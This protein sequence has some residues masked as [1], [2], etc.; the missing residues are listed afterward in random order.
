MKRSATE[1]HTE[2]QIQKE[3]STSWFTPQ[4]ASLKPRASSLLWVTV[5]VQGHNTCAILHCF[6][7][8][9]SR[10]VCSH[11]ILGL[12]S[13]DSVQKIHLSPALL[14]SFSNT[15]IH[16]LKNINKNAFLR[17][18]EKDCSEKP[19]AQCAQS[20]SLPQQVSWLILSSNNKNIFQSLGG[21]HSRHSQCSPDLAPSCFFSFL[22][23]NL[24]FFNN[25]LNGKNLCLQKHVEFNGVYF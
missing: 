21:N 25:R 6:S 14:V 16:I 18:F 4:M 15:Y 9:M 12:P 23:W 2:R 3:F 24:Q 19:P 20:P 13:I 5:W 8:L 7:R 17:R 22:I 11:G 1:G 10:Q